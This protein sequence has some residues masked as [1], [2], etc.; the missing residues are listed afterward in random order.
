MTTCPVRFEFYCGEEELKY[1]HNVPRNLVTVGAQ[2]AQKDAGYAKLFVNTLQPIIKEHEAVCLSNSNAFC[3]NCGSFRVTA[4]QTPMSWLQNV[5]DP[6]VAIWVNPVCGK[7]ECET[8]IRQQV[9][10]IM[11]KVVAEG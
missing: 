10:E 6:F 1:V 7:A 9:Q 8:Q 4:L 2:A 3:E 11:A 5:E